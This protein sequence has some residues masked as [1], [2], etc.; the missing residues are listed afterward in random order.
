MNDLTLFQFETQDVRIVDQDGNPWF[1][2]TDV[3]RVLELSNPSRAAERLRDHE[4]NT[5][6]LSEGNRGNPNVTIINE[7]GLYRLVMRSDKPQAERFQ[8]WVGDYPNVK[9]NLRPPKS[10]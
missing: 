9:V 5:L 4:R 6:T 7:R 3:C 8:D 1:V 10:P 2:L